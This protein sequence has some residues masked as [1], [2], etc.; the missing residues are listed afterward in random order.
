[1]AT[2]TKRFSFNTDL[3]SWTSSVGAGTT[4]SRST[5][6]ESTNDT[7]SGNGA[8]SLRIYGK[9]KTNAG[10]YWIWSGTWENLGV[11]SGNVVTAVNV[12]Y[13]WRC[14][15]FATGTGTNRVGPCVLLSSSDI[16]R[17]TFSTAQSSVTGSTS[18]ATVSGTEYSGISD[19]SNTTIKLK[20]TTDL[21]TGNSSTAAVT[22]VQD[23]IQVTIT[24]FPVTYKPRI[25]I[26]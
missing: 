20:I 3:E 16:T 5:T 4:A 13:D 22:M 14:S 10:N 19:A 6:E 25:I 12:S 26:I 23:W 24:Y 17:A 11:P 9:S 18:W 1:M 2:V 15:E 21:A 7:N 8:L